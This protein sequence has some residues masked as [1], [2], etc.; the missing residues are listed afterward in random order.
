MFRE[1]EMRGKPDGMI[2]TVLCPM[3]SVPSVVSI[4]AEGAAKFDRPSVFH[5][6]CIPFMEGSSNLKS[7]SDRLHLTQ[8]ASDRKRFARCLTHGAP[9]PA[10]PHAPNRLAKEMTYSPIADHPARA[11]RRIRWT[12]SSL[13]RRSNKQRFPRLVSSRFRRHFGFNR[14]C[15]ALS[16]PHVT[17]I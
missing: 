15:S 13:R 2:P 11:M 4:P 10:A 12:P 5:R 17:A 14:S 7:Q 9:P 6:G 1:K 8:R 16:R 3:H